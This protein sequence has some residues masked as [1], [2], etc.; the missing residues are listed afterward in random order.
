MEETRVCSKCKIEKPLSEFRKMKRCKGG[1]G[2]QCKICCNTRDKELRTSYKT[3]DI[4]RFIESGEILPKKYFKI[5]KKIGS[6]KFLVKKGTENYDTKS[7]YLLECMCGSTFEAHM[8][9]IN[10]FSSCG[11]KSCN[12]SANKIS[13]Q[14]SLIPESITED[15]FIKT[16]VWNDYASSAAKRNFNFELKV[17]DVKN[18]WLEQKGVCNLTGLKLSAGNPAKSE[19]HTWSINRK[20][21]TKGYTVNNVEIVHKFAN[22]IQN[23]FSLTAVDTYCIARALHLFQNDKDSAELIKNKIKEAKINPDILNVAWRE[24]LK[25]KK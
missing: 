3:A 8:A 7:I 21:S 19:T 14:N 20:D 17:E 13:A 12:Y 23:K 10:A 24:E 6:K 22:M 16:C 18:I 9:N 15:F 5:L 4:F 25:P 2:G 11:G 1:Y